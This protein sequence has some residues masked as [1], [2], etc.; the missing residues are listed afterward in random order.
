MNIHKIIKTSK[1]KTIAKE[2]N[3]YCNRFGTEYIYY[4]LIKY[5][6]MNEL[7]MIE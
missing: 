2:L 6:R 7:N 3:N 1:I 4:L 5:N